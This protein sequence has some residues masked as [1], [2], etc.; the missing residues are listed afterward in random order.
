MPTLRKR[1]DFPATLLSQQGQQL[2]ECYI[3][4]EIETTVT[5]EG[6]SVKWE[7]RI[8]SLSEPQHAYAGLY[9]ILPKN[10]VETVRVDIIRG[11]ES[12]LGITSDEYEFRGTGDPPKLP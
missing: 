10:G 1:K 9:G 3:F 2:S 5:Q 12:R 7:G 8:T 11:A 6:R 4:M